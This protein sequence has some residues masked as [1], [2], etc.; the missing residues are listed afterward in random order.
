MDACYG[1]LAVTRAVRAGSMR[2]L[3]DMMQ[4]L[5]R[6]VLT[7]GKADEVVADLG[8][9]L[10][11]H[12]VFTGHLINALKGAAADNQG[13]LT[14]WGVTTYVYQRVSSDDSS[15]QTPHYG[16]LHGDGDMIFLPLPKAPTDEELSKGTD[17][18]FAVPALLD[19]KDDPSMTEIDRLKELLL[20]P[21]HR[22]S[23]FDLIAQRTRETMSLTADDYFKVQ[24]LVTQENFVERLSNYEKL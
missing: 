11:N 23:L 18:L 5:S 9:P 22:I 19:R 20:E 6:Q 4:R 7:A 2:F 24:G 12:S 8:G 17:V 10:P 13:N 1:G 16:H 3:H 15:H 14:A 21:R